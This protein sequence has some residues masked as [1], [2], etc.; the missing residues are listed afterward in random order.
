MLSI[1]FLIKKILYPVV[2]LR[3]LYYYIRDSF[4]RPCNLSRYGSFDKNSYV[5]TPAYFSNQK[6]VYIERNAR[7]RCNFHL[8]NTTG[9][10]I[11]KKYSLIAPNC[12]VVTGNHTKNIAIPQIFSGTYH[13]NDIENDIIIGEDVW[14]GVNCTL[15]PG[16]NI[17]RGAI[18]GGNSMVNKSIPPYAVAVGSPAKVIAT[19]LAIEEIIEHERNLYSEDE[20]YSRSELESIFNTYYDGLTSKGIRPESLDT[21]LRAKLTDI[22]DISN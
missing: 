22:I 7:I 14:I 5:E 19:S 9:K 10:F 12:T 8:I 6:N 3:R 17:G 13:L 11:L 18:I 4:V 21:S 1:K 2:G 15:L 16:A 20:R